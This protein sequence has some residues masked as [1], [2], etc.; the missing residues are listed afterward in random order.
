MAYLRQR[1]NHTSLVESRR[2]AGK[3]KQRILTNLHGRTTISGALQEVERQICDLERALQCWQR[4]GEVEQILNH[5]IDTLDRYLERSL[6]G[7]R[8]HGGCDVTRKLQ[9]DSERWERRLAYLR[10]QR[11]HLLKVAATLS[12]PAL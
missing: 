4:I 2:V 10:D 11:E 5:R 9:G 8:P 12:S 3:V 1:G 7:H 6:K